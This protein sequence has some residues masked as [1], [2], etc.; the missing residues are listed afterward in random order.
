MLLIMLAGMD[1]GI[2]EQV[3]ASTIPLSGEGMEGILDTQQLVH[4]SALSTVIRIIS[5]VIRMQVMC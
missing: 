5:G 2:Q 3:L 4:V 1:F